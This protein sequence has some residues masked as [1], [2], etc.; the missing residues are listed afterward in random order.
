MACDTVQ[1]LSE[2]NERNFDVV[3]CPGL[4]SDGIKGFQRS[5]RQCCIELNINMYDLD[6]LVNIDKMLFL[7]LEFDRLIDIDRFTSKHMF[8]IHFSLLPKYRGVYT[9]IW[10]ILYGDTR[11][12]VTLHE[13]DRGIDTGDIV[14]QLAFK[15]QKD[16]T[17]RSLYEKYNLYGF[18][19]LKEC[20]ANLLDGSY[21]AKRQRVVGASYK[22]RS[23]LFGDWWVVDPNKT[24]YEISKAVRAF[25]FPEYQLPELCG[26][27]VVSCRPLEDRSIGRAGTILEETEDTI[28]VST[29]D[30]NIS[31]NKA[32]IPRYYE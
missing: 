30:Y 21:S 19:L 24:A 22:R 12:G 9:S 32:K 14:S 1:W 7:S 11:S 16:E 8:N 23:D 27:K 3:A 29:M 13:I 20:F 26:R 31:C 28:V 4:G 18:L 17:A 10:P 15:L 6:D 2:I 5:F 25:Y